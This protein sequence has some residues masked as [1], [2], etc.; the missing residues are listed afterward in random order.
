VEA[1]GEVASWCM[2]YEEAGIGQIDDVVT[3]R[4]H[5]RRG[6]GRAVVEAATRAS[7]ESGNQLT[8]LVADDEDWP[9]E[10]YARLGY[11]PLGCRYE[12]TRT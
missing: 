10:M 9:K 2:L 8:F 12:F 4:E 6:Y 5:R 7:L 1:D 3:A 11:E